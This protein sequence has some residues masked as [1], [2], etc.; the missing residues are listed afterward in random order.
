M[1]N[2]KVLFSITL[3]LEMPCRDILMKYISLF[4]KI[5]ALFFKSIFHTTKYFSHVIEA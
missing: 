3:N 1:F 5:R 2:H 4:N